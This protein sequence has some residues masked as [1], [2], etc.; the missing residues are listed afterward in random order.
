MTP[1]VFQL[2]LRSTHGLVRQALGA[3]SDGLD[4]HDGTAESLYQLAHRAAATIWFIILQYAE[5][6]GCQETR[7]ILD[8]E[9]IPAWPEAVPGVYD[10]LCEY[11]AVMSEAWTRYPAWGSDVVEPLECL[12]EHLA[13]IHNWEFIESPDGD[14]FFWR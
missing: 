12:W 6:L 9:A 5:F 3:I 13:A 7:D 2:K 10:F 14:I 11:K 4:A 1:E 8:A